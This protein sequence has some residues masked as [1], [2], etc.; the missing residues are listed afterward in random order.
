MTSNQSV[1]YDVNMTSNGLMQYKNTK[2]SKQILLLK[3]KE[4]YIYYKNS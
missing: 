3:V 4:L 1:M 2:K